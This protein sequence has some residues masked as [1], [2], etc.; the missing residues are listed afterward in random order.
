MNHP[1]SQG[2]HVPHAENSHIIRLRRRSVSELLAGVVW[3]IGLAVLL[4]YALSSFSENEHQAGILAGA[5]F[6][7]LLGAGIVIQIMRGIEARSQQRRRLTRQVSRQ[8]PDE[9][10]EGEQAETDGK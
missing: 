10:P 2:E 4:D 1:D 9:H 3:L 8:N 5:I 6:V 7:G